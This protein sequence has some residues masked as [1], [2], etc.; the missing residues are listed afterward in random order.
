MNLNLGDFVRFVDENIEGTITRIIDKDTI[1]VTDANDFEIPVLAS[2]VTLVHGDIPDDNTVVSNRQAVAAP[3]AEFKKEGVYLGLVADQHSAVVAHFH[4][5]NETSFQL[6]ASMTTEKG[7]TYKG[8]FAALIPANTTK[9]IYSA[10]MGD[11]Q[12][13]P[14][15]NIEVLFSTAA[16]VEPPAPL[17][18][19]ENIKGKDLSVAK[20]EIVL[21]KQKGWL[22]RLDEPAPVLD[23]QKLKEKFQ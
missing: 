12:L 1:G 6:L 14:K 18:Y 9:K 21:L 3:V 15:F 22:I 16:N 20:V 8:E 17:V 7:G 13:W 4:L 10:N 5:I 19:S 2:K 11:I 23:M